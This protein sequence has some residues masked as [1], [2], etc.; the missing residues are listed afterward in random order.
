MAALALIV[1]LRVKADLRSRLHEAA[2]ED[3]AAAVRDEPGCHRFDVLVPED[4]ADRLVLYEVYTDEAALAAHRKTPH[5]KAFRRV[6]DELA[7]AV[8][9]SRLRLSN[10]AA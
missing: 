1:E 6:L 7:V 8:T 5:L 9:V 2:V 4:A 3:A 10:E